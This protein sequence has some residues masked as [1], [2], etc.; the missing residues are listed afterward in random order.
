ME[1]VKITSGQLFAIM[2]LF[3]LGSALVIGLGMDAKKDAWLAILFGWVGGVIILG[4][5]MYLFLQYPTLP[6]TGYLQKILGKYIGWFL[7][8][9][10]IMYFIYLS[11]RVLRDFGELLISSAYDQTPLFV[12]NSLMIVTIAYVL[13]KGIEA[14]VRTGWILF[15]MMLTLGL[16]GIILIFISG[17]AD[18]KNLLPILEKGWKPVLNT[19][20]PLTF[21]FPFGEMIIFTMILPYLNKPQQAVKLG[22]AAITGSAIVLMVATITNI[23]VLGVN[24]SSRATFPLLLTIGKVNIMN[25][26]QRLDMMV[27]LTLIIGGFIKIS[28]FYYAAVMGTSDL[29]KVKKHRRL[30]FPTGMIILFSSMQIAHNFTDHLIEGLKVVPIYLHLPLQTGIPLLLLAI[31]WFRKQWNTKH[32]KSAPQKS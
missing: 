30:I 11:S 15:L 26:L 4:I 5:Y 10:Y 6:L 20:F 23:A 28:L 25:L 9:I 1:K 14:F 31:S 24:I 18:M 21:T 22:Y 12:I 7:G 27:I 8:L 3:E 19:A 13:H 17:I 2:V 32:S 16:L 29:F